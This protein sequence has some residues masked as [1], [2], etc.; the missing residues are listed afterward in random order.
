M[1]ER[2]LVK[3]AKALDKNGIPYMII[4]G[5]AVLLYGVPRL[6]EDIDITLGI[7]VDKAEKLKKIIK[8]LNFKIP[9][10]VNENFIKETNVLVAID[11]KSGIRI[12]F[13]FSYSSYEQECIKRARSV[14]IQGYKVRFS[15]CE[16][17][18]IH[19]IFAGRE[20]DLED[21]RIIIQKNFEKIDKNYIRKWLREFS[22]LPEQKDALKIFENLLSEIKRRR[23]C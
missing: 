7:D 9:K 17:L 5:Q 4:G 11:K 21:T 10:G 6:T 19:K 2:L 16:D 8:G 22:A 18:I 3:I 23:R 15:S 13:I 1:I 20:R 12:D 14:N